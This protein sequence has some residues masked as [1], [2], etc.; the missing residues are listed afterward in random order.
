M[1]PTPNAFVICERPIDLFVG[2]VLAERQVVGVEVDAGII[3]LLAHASEIIERHSQP[4]LPKLFDLRSFACARDSAPCVKLSSARTAIFDVRR[5]E[6]AIAEAVGHH[7]LDGLIDRQIPEA[8]GLHSQ[9]HPIDFGIDHPAES[10]GKRDAA[11]RQ[12]ANISS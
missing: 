12:F 5:E 9:L 8:V 1:I 10:R 6:L 7:S 11:K 4:P 3:E 2:C